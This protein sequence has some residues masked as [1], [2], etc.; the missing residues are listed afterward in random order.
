M[1]KRQ[2]MKQRWEWPPGDYAARF[3]CGACVWLWRDAD[4]LQRL[5]LSQLLGVKRTHRAHREL[6]RV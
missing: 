3:W 6:F 2:M 1:Q 4:L 5:F